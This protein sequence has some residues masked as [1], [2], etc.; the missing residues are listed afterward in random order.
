MPDEVF[1]ERVCA[2]V[3]P[4]PEHAVTLSDLTSFLDSRG[5]SREWFPEGLVIVEDLPRASGAK[6]AKG[7]LRRDVR[8]RLDDGTVS[9][10]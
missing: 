10:A 4:R 5:V 1:G 3:V 7:E 8:R 9:L 2:Y 6:V